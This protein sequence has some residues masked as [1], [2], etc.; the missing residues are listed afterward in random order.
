MHPLEP[1]PAPDDPGP[2]G[3]TEAPAPADPA[4]TPGG[5]PHRDPTPSAPGT[6]AQVVRPQ[7]AHHALLNVPPRD[8]FVLL[9]RLLC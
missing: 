3:E 4:G 9:Q 7:P 1:S 6:R 5:S 8:L 2:G